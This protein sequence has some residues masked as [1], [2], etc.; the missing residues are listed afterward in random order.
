VI[1]FF[2]VLKSAG[3]GE[4]GGGARERDREREKERERERERGIQ[5][6]TLSAWHHM[7]IRTFLSLSLSLLFFFFSFL[8]FLPSFGEFQIAL[9]A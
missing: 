8:F 2:G 1:K 7:G 5:Q 3:A 4:S 6:R 9:S